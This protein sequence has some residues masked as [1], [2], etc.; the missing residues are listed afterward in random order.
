LL[1]LLN[2]LSSDIDSVQSASMVIY[3]M[4]GLVEPTLGYHSKVSGFDDWG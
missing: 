1:G 3:R 4:V 2:V